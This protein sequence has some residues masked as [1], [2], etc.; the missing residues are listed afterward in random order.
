MLGIVFIAVHTTH[1]KNEEVYWGSTALVL[2]PTLSLNSS[3]ITA[4]SKVEGAERCHYDTVQRPHQ[5]YDGS[6]QQQ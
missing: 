1:S 4:T 6:I 5:L 3:Q 2:I